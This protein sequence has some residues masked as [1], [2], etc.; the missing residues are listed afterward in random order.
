MSGPVFAAPRARA[1][2]IRSL[3]GVTDHGQVLEAFAAVPRH[4]FVPEAI[5]HLAYEDQALPIG[6]GQTI[7]RPGT[8]AR[9]TTALLDEP[10]ESVLE[11]GTGS[12]FQ[13]ALLAHL[14]ARVCTVERVFDLLLAALQRLES[15]AVGSLA[16]CADMAAPDAGSANSGGQAGAAFQVGN[17]MARVGNGFLGWPEQGPFDGIIVT[18]APRHV[19]R[20]LLDQLAVGGRLVVPV[21]GGESQALKIVDR[22]ED[23]FHERV[24]ET[25]R[26]VPL[27][28]E[29]AG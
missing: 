6:H 8:V 4:L 15:L 5:S 24:G 29:R 7:S 13:T 10:R 17:V 12:G 2:L 9:M 18:A 14:C 21:G 27:V 25:V 3:E 16:P 11:V 20:A 22:D 28:R 19:P 1:R 26:F 23:G